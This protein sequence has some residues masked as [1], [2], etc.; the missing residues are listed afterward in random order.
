MFDVSIRKKSSAG[1]EWTSPQTEAFA[2]RE[3]YLDE[4]IDASSASRVIVQL[5]ELDAQGHDPI[6]LFINSP[7]GS[8]SDGF[9]IIDTIRA[10]ESPVRTVAIGLA[11]SMAAVI[12]ACGERGERWVAPNASVL[13]HQ[14]L[15]GASGQASDLKIAIER[16]LALKS[17]LNRLLAEATG[18]STDEVAAVADRDSWFDAEDAVRCGLADR[19]G[20]PM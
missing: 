4:P 12:L 16:I 1:T 18:R 15:G 7:G 5:R 20:V 3:V 14:P 19:V 6:T 2:R 13:V 8:V 11:A 9:A 10:L 17:R